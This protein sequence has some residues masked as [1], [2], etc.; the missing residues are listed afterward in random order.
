MLGE[1]L[2]Y[3]MVFDVEEFADNDLREF[4]EALLQQPFEGGAALELREEIV[5]QLEDEV[6]DRELIA[7]WPEEY[8]ELLPE[9]M[10]DYPRALEQFDE[11]LEEVTEEEAESARLIRFRKCLS[12]LSPSS[13]W[14]ERAEAARG[15]GSLEDEMYV[16]RDD[17]V[18]KPLTLAEISLSSLIAH[19]NLFEAVEEW[20]EA[21]RLTH[22]GKLEEA[23]ETALEGSRLMRAI[24]QWGRLADLAVCAA[25]W[26]VN[27]EPES[28]PSDAPG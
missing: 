14:E 13:G 24:E 8:L 17:Y 6:L 23:M 15:L 2:L 3:L 4:L 9:M 28:E 25:L 20:R 11:I 18:A 12:L 21:F 26:P 19:R 10:V 7:G 16:F 27:N 1:L 22:Q 5:A